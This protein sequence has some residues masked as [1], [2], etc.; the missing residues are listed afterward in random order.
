[1]ADIKK[2][3]EAEEMVEIRIPRHKDPRLPQED[4]YSINFKNYII[5]RGEK[6]LV[7]KSLAKMIEDNNEAEEYAIIYAEEHKMR[8]PVM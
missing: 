2:K 4:F 1:M 8:Q 5:K 7:P 6:V 3:A